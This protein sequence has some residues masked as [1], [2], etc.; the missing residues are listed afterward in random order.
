MIRQA[1]QLLYNQPKGTVIDIPLEHSDNPAAYIQS[2]EERVNFP[3]RSSAYTNDAISAG[4]FR[5][6]LTNTTPVTRGGTTGGCLV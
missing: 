3:E 5:M 1:L 4:L 2:F 6:T